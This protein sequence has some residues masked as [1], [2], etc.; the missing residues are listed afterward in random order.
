VAHVCISIKIR[1]SQHKKCN[2][3]WTNI[4]IQHKTTIFIYI[5]SEMLL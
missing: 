5:S 4:T 2:K 1:N 3:I